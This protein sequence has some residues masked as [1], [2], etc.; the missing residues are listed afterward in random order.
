MI[1]ERD[2]YIDKLKRRKHNGLIKIVTGMRRSGKSF[3]LFNLFVQQLRNEGVDDSHIILIDLEDYRNIA[4][5]QPDELLHYVDDRLL[6]DKM[7]YLLIDE[8]QRLDHFEEVLNSFLKRNN[9]DVYVTGSNARFLSRDVITIFRGRSDEVR[10]HPF[11]FKEYM[12]LQN[13]VNNERALRQYLTYGGMP[14]CVLMDTEEQKKEYL[15]DLF[16]GTYLRDIK[17]RYNLR[18]DADMEELIDV[19]A[20]SIGSLVNPLKLKN[21]FL[22]VKKSVITVDTIKTYLDLLQDSF[23][24]E[25]SVRYDIKGRRY[26]ETPAKYYFDDL[27]LRNARLGF[28]QV[29]YTH[30]LENLIYNELR[31]RGQM[32]DV[33]QVTLNKKNGNGESQRTTLEVDFVCNQGDR[34]TYIQS[35]YSMIDEEKTEQELRPLMSIDDGFQKVVIVGGMQPTYRNDKGI[36]ILNLFDFLLD[37]GSLDIRL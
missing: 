36:L 8:V 5:R 2:I 6:D 31:I 18:N 20:S 15:K 29:E 21:T 26:I 34:R 22:S 32:V 24:L 23:I 33:G 35:A 17:E 27:G 4:L 19:L 28:R 12:T 7:H 30:L 16:T 37:D 11:C 13:G 14:Q 10:I 9:V 25:K 3:L 1:V